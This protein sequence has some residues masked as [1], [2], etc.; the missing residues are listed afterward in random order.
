MLPVQC[1]SK[2]IRIVHFAFI[3]RHVKTHLFKMSN[4]VKY[5]PT[6]KVQSSDT[7]IDSTNSLFQNLSIKNTESSSNIVKVKSELAT[8]YEAFD[9]AFSEIEAK[10]NNFQLIED[11]KNQI[12]GMFKSVLQNFGQLVLVS[13]KSCMNEKCWQVLNTKISTIVKHVDSK[14]E[15]LNTV[16]KRNKKLIQNTKYVEP[17]E[18]AIGLKWRTKLSSKTDLPDHTIDHLTFQH[19]PILNTLRSLFAQEEFKNEYFEFNLSDKHV[20]QKGIYKYFCCTDV[21]NNCEI[22]N[23]K[24]A[25]KIRLA[26]DDCDVCDPV[27]SKSVIHKLTCVYFTID[28]MPEKRLARTNNIFLVAL[29]E[30]SNLKADDNT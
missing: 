1:T 19:I 10:I 26:V 3:D 20:C 2:Y 9:S 29:C 7:E 6:K 16:Y 11:H 18:R 14:I 8:Q 4:I 24:A 5:N 13:S 23:D 21:Y 15:K 30:P 25:I 28:N 17:I 12:Y 22:Y 27:K